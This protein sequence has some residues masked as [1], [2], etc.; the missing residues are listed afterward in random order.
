MKSLPSSACRDCRYILRI[1]CWRWH[2]RT[3][4]FFDTQITVQ[5]VLGVAAC[6][7]KDQGCDTGDWHHAPA[8]DTSRLAPM[9]HTSSGHLIVY[10]KHGIA[11]VIR[12]FSP[13]RPKLHEISRV[14]PQDTSS[15][16]AY[17]NRVL[18]NF[19][20]TQ[21]CGKVVRSRRTYFH[22]KRA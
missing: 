20:G 21:C 22:G 8:L 16:V 11:T 9:F 14:P 2:I 13:L 15:A 18:R 3:S 5:C 17:T 7:V 4:L 19:L 1:R 12:N 6:A 10:W